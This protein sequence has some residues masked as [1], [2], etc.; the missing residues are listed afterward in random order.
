MN[1]V[2]LPKNFLT[3]NVSESHSG[4]VSKDDENANDADIA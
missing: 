1:R 3:V 2:K 4:D